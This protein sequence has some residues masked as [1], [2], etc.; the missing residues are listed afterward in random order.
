[1]A[2][3][4]FG[5]GPDELR[6]QVTQDPLGG[7]P[8]RINFGVIE[9]GVFA[10]NIAEWQPVE[11]L[12]GTEPDV[13]V[14]RGDFDTDSAFYFSFINDAIA[15]AEDRNVQLVGATI[16]G[17]AIP[18]S[19]LE[20]FVNGDFGPIPF[21]GDAQRPVDPPPPAP[22]QNI[23]GTGG[24]DTLT[25]TAGNDRIQGLAGDDWISGLGGNDVIRGGAG[26]DVLDGGAGNDVLFTS[27]GRDTVLFGKDGFGRDVVT[28]FEI[29]VD[30]VR[31]VGDTTGLRTT[32]LGGD[33]V[34]IGF[35]D[36]D[37]SHLVLAGVGVNEVSQA[38][39]I[40]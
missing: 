28:D 38:I 40:A 24:A 37:R 35:G 19:S 33:G 2:T 30:Q 20:A 17:T 25:G 9:N 21:N 8:S 4:E 11:A 16:N 13:F 22:G 31:L 1:M 15:G 5:E 10:G 3:T 6:F 32:S 18:G 34:L 7:E 39:V 23:N 14:V 27:G 29:G 26:S 36:D 12:R